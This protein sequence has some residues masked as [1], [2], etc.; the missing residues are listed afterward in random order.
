M[1]VSSASCVISPKTSALLISSLGHGSMP[2]T[3]SGLYVSNSRNL[4]YYCKYSY[5]L[6]T[7]NRRLTLNHGRHSR[8]YSFLLSFVLSLPPRR[9]C[10]HIITLSLIPGRCQMF[11][12][13]RHPNLFRC[14]L[15]GSL[16]NQVLSHTP[17]LLSSTAGTTDSTVKF[18]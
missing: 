18:A 2:I 15:V 6:P 5:S 8:C 17:H 3:A 9:I 13:C 10:R 7:V 11:L 16:Y 14:P 4:K 12:D 1:P